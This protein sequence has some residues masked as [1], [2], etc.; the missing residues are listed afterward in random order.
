[1]HLFRILTAAAAVV[2]GMAMSPAGMAAS[3]PDQPA[4]MHL[5]RGGGG[6]GHGGGF[7]GHGGG[8][9][10]HGGGFRGGYAERGGWGYHPW[11]PGYWV[12]GPYA[13]GCPY[14]YSYPYCTL[15]YG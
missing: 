11:G 4:L 14:P 13:Y 6:G 7:G 10:G 8:F 12:G 1:M 3:T 5:V 2:A 15:P 9:G